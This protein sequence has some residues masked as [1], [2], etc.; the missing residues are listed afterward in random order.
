MIT[1]LEGP[2]T[3]STG[4]RN[5]SCDAPSRAVG[6]GAGRRCWCL[7]WQL[8]GVRLACTRE[9]EGSDP[10]ATSCTPYRFG[11]RDAAAC[12]ASH[13]VP[14]RTQSHSASLHV[15][16]EFVLHPC[17]PGIAGRDGASPEFDVLGGKSEN[18]AALGSL[19]GLV[20]WELFC[21]GAAAAAA[22]GRIV[23]RTCHNG[24]ERRS[25]RTGRQ[26]MHRRRR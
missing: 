17:F 3:E 24:A 13:G 21:A 7:G 5:L 2:M 22:A 8:Q 9:A 10:R 18:A 11:R 12:A 25:L 1:R 20:E 14:R 16:C 19:D 26:A 4:V 23:M 6:Q 15:R